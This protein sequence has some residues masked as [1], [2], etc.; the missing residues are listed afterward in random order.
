M[1]SKSVEP[2]TV[3]ETI[4]RSFGTDDEVY[5][6]VVWRSPTLEQALKSKLGIRTKDLY[7][8]IIVYEVR[9][10]EASDREIQITASRFK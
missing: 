8:D 6:F 4:Q 9:G 3:E 2:L 1:A 5:K 10:Y 7:G